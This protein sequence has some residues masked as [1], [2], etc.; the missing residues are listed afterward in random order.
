MAWHADS[1]SSAASSRTA[2]Q[3]KAARSAINKSYASCEEL[4]ARNDALKGEGRLGLVRTMALALRTSLGGPLSVQSFSCKSPKRSAGAGIRFLGIRILI[5]DR[6]CLNAKHLVAVRT[7]D[8][9]GLSD[10]LGGGATTHW[11]GRNDLLGAPHCDGLG[12]QDR[13]EC[14]ESGGEGGRRSSFSVARTAA[15]PHSATRVAPMRRIGRPLTSHN[16]TD[17]EGS[18][19]R[20]E[21]M[22]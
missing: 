10:R 19:R 12:G 2:E 18:C 22:F 7:T 3:K 1:L 13:L 15:G 17:W 9:E 21:K 8:W 16:A 20:G 6:K 4:V 11:D 5:P 14:D